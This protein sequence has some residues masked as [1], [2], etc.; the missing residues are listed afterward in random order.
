MKSLE[1]YK[2]TSDTS[3]FDV[4][5]PFFVARKGRKQIRLPLSGVPTDAPPSATEY[6]WNIP[7]D[8]GQSLR[9]L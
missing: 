5:T 1:S 9:R 7:A 2:K 6:V 8:N 4:L 3:N